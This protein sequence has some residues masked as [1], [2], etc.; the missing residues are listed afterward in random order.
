MKMKQTLPAMLL[1]LTLGSGSVM[2]SGG[3]PA[4]YY[5]EPTAGEFYLYSLDQN[6]FV[7]QSGSNSTTL[8]TAAEETVTLEQNAD[9][10]AYAVKMSHGKYMKLGSWNGQFL[11]TDSQ[12]PVYWT[13]D[14]QADQS[15]TVSTVATAGD[16][17]NDDGTV[18]YLNTTQ[19]DHLNAWR[20]TQNEKVS[21][22]LITPA[23]YAQYQQSGD[24]DKALISVAR[25][26]LMVARTAT[27]LHDRVVLPLRTSLSDVEWDVSLSSPA[28]A[29]DETSGTLSVASRTSEV[30]P[31][32]LLQAYVEVGG[33][34]QPVWDEP[35]AIRVAPDDD[36]Y[37]YLYCHMPNM[38]PDLGPHQTVNQVVTF[39]LGRQEDLGLVFN[40]L[41]HGHAIYNDTVYGA[42][43]RDE[44]D[45]AGR[46]PWCRDAHICKDPQRGCY[47]IVT[48]DL[49]GS[50][51]GGNSMMKNYS[52]GMF[53][54]YDLINWTYSRCDLKEY[55]KAHPVSDIY[56]DAGTALMTHDKVSRVWAP[57]TIIVD[58]T[59][60]IYYAVGNYDNGDNDHF[61]LSRANE[62][63]TGIETFEMLFGTNRLS[64]ILD[65][66]IVFNE[67][68]QLYHMSHRDYANGDIRDL[69]CPDLL[70]HEWSEQPVSR[71]FGAGGFEASTQFR[72]IN[73]DEWVI[74]NVQYTQRI[75]V[76]NHVANGLLRDLKDAPA[77]SGHVAAQHGSV[78]QINE[79]EWR[80]LQRWSDIKALLEATPDDTA[81][82]QALKAQQLLARQAIKQQ[83]ASR[84]DMHQL[85]ASL[86]QAFQQ[87]QAANKAYKGLA[88]RRQLGLKEGQTVG[89]LLQDATE[90]PIT[91]AEPRTENG[92]Q[93][94]GFFDHAGEGSGLFE[95]WLS[96]NTVQQDMLRTLTGLDEGDY[97][98]SLQGFY[99][100]GDNDHHGRDYEEDVEQIN[101][102]LVAGSERTPIASFYSVKAEGDGTWNGYVDNLASA[103]RAMADETCY[104]TWLRAHVGQDGQ[105]TIG[106]H[107]P[108]GT[109]SSTCEWA[110]FK[111]FR[112]Y[113]L[114]AEATT[115]SEIGNRKSVDSKYFDLQGRRITGTM[116]KGIYVENGK[117]VIVK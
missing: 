5:A 98:V 39:A 82:G 93:F 40:E 50:L 74:Q 34:R 114:S 109:V 44:Q 52:I 14:Q 101:Y 22:A 97:L 18:Y 103:A 83:P 113:K 25:E 79:D 69:T 35:F 16:G 85:A 12:Q 57:Q 28:A 58:G 9:A 68:D 106:L 81:E 110:C 102:Q 80:V 71:I 77:V 49:T 43:A 76:Y 116:Q 46:L 17:L 84:I 108:E 26:E 107:R 56:N 38:V 70:K 48:T 36:A 45:T 73:S 78:I 86:E 20:T 72:R 24:Y 96:R 63:F 105:L 75:G 7:K 111:G 90:V 115:I 104:M 87:L 13:F 53:R 95:F 30:Q 67:V 11:W 31:A 117:K 27:Y 112:I 23:A 65:A 94:S 41:N 59:P 99:R 88:L 100:N 10:T 33:E 4:Q 92:W 3:I 15:W 91:G 6:K 62:N 64:N 42:V 51:D 61:Y 89:D 47:Y 2:A 19:T 32:G 29:Y 21:F 1:A 8:T 60:Y 66:D 37:G 55:L 54:S